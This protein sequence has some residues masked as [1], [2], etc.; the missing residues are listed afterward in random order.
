MKELI[1][2][3]KQKG[4][5]CFVGVA[6]LI[7]VHTYTLKTDMTTWVLCNFYISGLVA[8]VLIGLGVKYL[9]MKKTDVTQELNS[10]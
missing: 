5:W 1:I 6:L 10:I 3:D 4:L 9:F 8:T 7:F 2:G